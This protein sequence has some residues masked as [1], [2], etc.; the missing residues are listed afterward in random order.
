MIY[1]HVD[2]QSHFG[3]IDKTLHEAPATGWTVVGMKD[4]WKTIFAFQQ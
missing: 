1:K 4:D 2:R 3:K